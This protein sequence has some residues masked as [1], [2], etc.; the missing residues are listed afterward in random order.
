MV[1]VCP[2]GQIHELLHNGDTV[3]MQIG[4]YSVLTENLMTFSA[5]YGILQTYDRFQIDFITHKIHFQIGFA[6]HPVFF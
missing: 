1:R 5:L 4:T 3:G 2:L 6:F